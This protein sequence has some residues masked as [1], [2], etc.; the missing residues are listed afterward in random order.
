MTV[1]L[2]ILLFW[3]LAFGVV[4]GLAPRGLSGLALVAG[5]IVP[6]ALAA[7][8]LVHF[9]ASK[10]GLQYLTD[11]AWIR[12][13]G[14]RYKLGIDGLNVWLVGLT[15]LLFAA[16]ALWTALRP[17]ERSPRLYGFQLGRTASRRRSSSWC[18]RWSARC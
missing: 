5:A 18:T 14:I 6:L 8:L 3:P 4:A 1:H 11:D 7:V 17:P 16:V 15:A 12:E 2:S 13:L 9:D 10:T